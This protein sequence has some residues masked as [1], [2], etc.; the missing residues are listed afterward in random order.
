MYIYGG[1]Y[2]VLWI[3]GG[4][5]GGVFSTSVDGC[6]GGGIELYIYMTGFDKTKHLGIEISLDY[7]FINC[8][9]LDNFYLITLKVCHYIAQRCIVLKM[10]F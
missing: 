7:I 6:I 3:G 10:P 8:S 4:S 2:E 5:L 1:I 9:Y